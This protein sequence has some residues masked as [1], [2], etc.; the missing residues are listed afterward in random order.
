MNDY[1]DYGDWDE[2]DRPLPENFWE[3][4]PVPLYWRVLIK[5]IPP[6]KMSR[7]GIAIPMSA[8]ESQNVLNYLGQVIAV[9]PMAG[10]SEKLGARGDGVSR[11]DGFPKKGDY[12]TY[13]RYQGQRVTHRGV[14]MLFIN[15]DEILAV[16]PNPDTLQVTV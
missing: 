9:G 4:L 12:V 13:A 5:P 16:V 6:K 3:D 11:A 15:D 2:E 10:T 8:Q 7:G 14:R 1:S